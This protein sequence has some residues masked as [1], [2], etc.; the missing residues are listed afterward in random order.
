MVL[1]EEHTTPSIR[2]PAQI[3]Y[4]L[5]ANL[6]SGRAPQGYQGSHDNPNHKYIIHRL[7]ADLRVW[8]IRSKIHNPNMNNLLPSMDSSSLSSELRQM[9]LNHL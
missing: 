7:K 3:S 6:K 1:S 2:S 9:K 8:P 5:L 4:S